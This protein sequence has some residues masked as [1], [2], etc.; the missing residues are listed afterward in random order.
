MWE[1]PALMCMDFTEAIV[2]K[3]FEHSEPARLY[4][5]NKQT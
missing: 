3:N 4:K 2:K 1:T 5:L